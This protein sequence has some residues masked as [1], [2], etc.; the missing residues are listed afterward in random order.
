MEL[1]VRRESKGLPVHVSDDVAV[2]VLTVSSSGDREVLGAQQ[3]HVSASYVFYRRAFPHIAKR[4]KS[5]HLHL[6]KESPSVL[7]ILRRI[8][9]CAAPFVFGLSADDHVVEFTS[10]N[11]DDLGVP[12][13]LRI[14]GI[15]AEQRQ[16]IF[17]RPAVVSKSCQAGVGVACP[18]RV[19]VITRVVEIYFVIDG[20][21]RAGVDALV[22]VTVLLVGQEAYAQ[23]LPGHQVLGNNVIPVLES[24]N[25]PPG[26]PLIEKVPAVV[27]PDKTVGVVHQP[28]H[29]LIVKSLSVLG[30]ADSVIKLLELLRVFQIA[31]FFLSCPLSHLG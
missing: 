4:F 26:A 28:G 27:M 24:V 7:Q 16:R 31:I 9:E 17:L 3:Q 13:V 29:S 25:S 22:V 18:V 14:V 15:G 12:L 8:D 10:R 6:S 21:G 23:V 19:A 2:V 30:P 1:A 20:H 11:A 5:R